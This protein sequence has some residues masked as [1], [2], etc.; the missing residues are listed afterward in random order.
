MIQALPS[1]F[2]FKCNSCNKQWMFC[3]SPGAI[4]RF[5]SDYPMLKKALSRCVIVIE[6]ER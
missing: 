2:G 1:G 3:D 4:R 6:E 5:T